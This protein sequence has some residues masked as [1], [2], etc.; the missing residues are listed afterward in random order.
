[1][2]AFPPSKERL[3][4]AYI[5]TDYPQASQTYIHEE[6]ASLKDDYNIKVFTFQIPDL[7]KKNAYPYE[8]TP[9]E[10]L[11]EKVREFKP[12]VMHSHYLI[13]FKI[14]DEI[15]SK[16]A[17]PYTIRSHSFDIL[18]I[19]QSRLVG[20]CQ[21]SLSPACLRILC[22]PDLIQRLVESGVPKEKIVPC[23]PVVNYQ[24]FYRPEKPKAKNKILNVGA[25]IEKKNYAEFI[26]L[27]Y[28]MR[29]SQKEFNLYVIGYDTAKLQA[30]NQMRGNPV[31]TIAYAEYDEM[32]SVYQ[33]H[34][35]LVYTGDP[36]INALGLPLS[37]AEAQASG[38]G[39]CLQ[40]MPGRKQ[41]FLN[42]LGG[43]GFLF[44]G[45]EEL[46]SILNQPYPEEMRVRG[47]EN[48]KKCDI[49]EH[50]KLLTEV[51]DLESDVD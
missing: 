16:L 49:Y 15:S 24:K 14:L 32:P 38:I 39:V 23:W 17:I 12:H 47:L 37:I 11:L 48:A 5:I 21:N 36:I 34:D 6:I 13:T 27:A 18:G 43:A 51:W 19:S 2:S 8:F 41:G 30:Y 9:R 22:F 4:I 29:S 25:A 46:P 20:L 31:K 44:Q 50:N 42:Y 3:R 28:N 35:W 33:S 45:I 1:M 7:I 40:E 10:G 26:D